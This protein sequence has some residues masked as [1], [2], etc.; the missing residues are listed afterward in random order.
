MPSPSFILETRIS[1]LNT[2]LTR[3]AEQQVVG[4]ALQA[5]NGDWAAALPGLTG[6][7]ADALLQEG[8]S[9]VFAG[10]LVG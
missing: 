9:G 7:L 4:D 2:V 1:A 5:S 10:G 8:C 6:K 3:K